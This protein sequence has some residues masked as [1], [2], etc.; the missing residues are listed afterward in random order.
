M[1]IRDSYCA[2]AYAVLG[3]AMVR[4]F[5]LW[6]GDPIFLEE[7]RENAD[8]ALSL[9][10]R[11]ALAHTA[12][13]FANH[14]SGHSDDAQREYRLAMQ[15]DQEE[16]LAHRLLG[17]IYAREGNFKR[18]TG[19]LQRA[20]GLKPS[21]IAT[22]D[23]F[24]NVL[25]RLDRYEEALEIADK[26]IASARKRVKEAVDDFDA[27]LHAAMLYVRLGRSE[28]AREEVETSLR[29]APRD[30]FVCYHA[31][32]VHALIADPDDLDVAVKLLESARARG[33]YLRNELIRNT[34]LDVLRSL[35]RFQE[36]EASH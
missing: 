20:I 1:C 5:Q 10:S 35:P 9:E 18:A 17:S 29:Q 19:L 33:F 6:D 7:A 30:G 22:Y 3:E 24:H 26:G 16:W 11:N 15:C 36:L 27:R 21:H 32:C 14:L 23:H 34:D 2:D 25:V 12:L 28:E 31:A 8:K 4:K 13:A